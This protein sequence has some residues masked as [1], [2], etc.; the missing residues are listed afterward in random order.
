MFLPSRLHPKI[1]VLNR[2]IGVMDSGK[3]KVRGLEVRKRDSPRFVYNAQTDMINVLANANNA[4]ELYG[5]IP[6]AI[7]VLREYRQY[8]LDGKVPLS[9]LVV[10]KHMSK[11]P[12]RYRQ[13]VSQVIVAKQLA[14]M[15]SKCRREPNTRF[16][17]PATGI[18]VTS[19]GLRRRS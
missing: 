2:Y 14:P 19:A 11:E 12:K 3:I 13:Q 4:K 15:V 1:G 5:Q 10:S 8:L 18:S 6:E 16:S 17:T 7:K 9:E